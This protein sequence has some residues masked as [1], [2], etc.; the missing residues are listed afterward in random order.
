[1]ART[2]EKVDDITV[3]IIDDTPKQEER[4]LAEI[5][6]EKQK[7]D[8]NLLRLARDYNDVKTRLEA[9][10]AQLQADIDAADAL[11][12]GFFIAAAIRDGTPDPAELDTEP[13]GR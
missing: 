4:I 1:M 3:R 8:A 13:E 2:Y 6:E 10:A 11:G 7:V 12:V 9:R 5:H